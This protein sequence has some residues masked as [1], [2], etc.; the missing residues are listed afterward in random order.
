MSNYGKVIGGITAPTTVSNQ[1]QLSPLNQF[2]GLAQALGGTTGTNG[3][4]GSLG[5]DKTLLGLGK[6]IGNYHWSSVFSGNNQPFQN[7]EPPP[8]GYVAPNVEE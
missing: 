8:E 7:Y 5:I 6:A 2:A 3:I 1:T 4:L